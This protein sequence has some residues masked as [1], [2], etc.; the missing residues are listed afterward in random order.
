MGMFP[1]LMF[2]TLELP[3][4]LVLVLYIHM[5]MS[6]VHMIS[7]HGWPWAPKP[8]HYS[9]PLEPGQACLTFQ[10]SYVPDKASSLCFDTT[11]TTNESS[12]WQIDPALGQF[13]NVT[14]QTQF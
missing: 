5:A 2:M 9:K 13:I 6:E 10:S 8:F 4:V 7:V 1:R 3:L 14:N 12:S 11:K